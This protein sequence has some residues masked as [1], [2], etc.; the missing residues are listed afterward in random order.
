[1]KERFEV[2]MTKAFVNN[3]YAEFIKISKINVKNEKSIL[4]N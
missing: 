4:M 1:M 3:I 2:E